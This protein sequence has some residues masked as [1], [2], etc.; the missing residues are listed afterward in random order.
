MRKRK[1]RAKKK[2]RVRRMRIERV[3]KK[4]EKNYTVSGADK[5]IEMKGVKI[6]SVTKVKERHRRENCF[7][8]CRQTNVLRESQFFFLD[9]RDFDL[10]T[11]P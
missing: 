3:K 9:F 6:K 2:K 4:E 5:E 10:Q 7:T 1:R 8:L 11:R